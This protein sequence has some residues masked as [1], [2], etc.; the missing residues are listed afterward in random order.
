MAPLEALL[1]DL[2]GTLIDSMPL[3]H[4]SWRLWHAQQ[5]LPFDEAGFFA[6]TAGRT[7]AEILADLFPQR[8]EAE[9]GQMAEAKESLYRELAATRLTLVAGALEL[10]AAAAA[11]G[12][13]CAICTAA[14]T[15][16]IR[17]AFERF[18]LGDL[19]QTV[20][21]PADRVHGG[22]PDAHLRGKPHPDIFLE[23]ARRLAVDP[24]RCLV[25]EDAPLGVEAARRAG[26]RALAL[27]TTLPATAFAACSNLVGVAADLR[28]F[29]LDTL[30]DR[31]PGPGP[32]PGHGH[33]HGFGPDLTPHDTARERSCAKAPLP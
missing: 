28:S 10:L 22:A 24:A 32:G 19:V 16:N 4:E 11:R 33:D 25:F 17:V 7:N 14:P 3:H 26:M 30:V 13:A 6:A 2:D 21:S 31:W 9:R 15:G 18:G 5:R 1:F 27:T 8:S 12:L 29:D 20:T 23:A